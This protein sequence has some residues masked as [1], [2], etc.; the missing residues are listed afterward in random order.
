MTREE[1]KRRTRDAIVFAARGLFIAQ[2]YNPTTVDKIARAAGVSRQ[3]FY[4]HF[5]SKAHIVQD[6]MHT[7]GPEILDDYRA[8]DALENPGIPE[9]LDWL[10]GHAST[11]RRYRM[12]FTVMEQSR[13]QDPEVAAEWFTFTSDIVSAFP[14]ALNAQR[15]GGTSE[16]LA[17]AR[18]QVAVMAVDRSF[19]FLLLQGHTEDEPA[20]MTALAELFAPH[21]AR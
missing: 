5:R 6:L 21:L 13:A 9:I 1:Q 19:H 10:A 2:G 16:A 17:R 3:G 7:I 14:R 12:E 20:E 4:L 11:W 18:L 8:L 15:R